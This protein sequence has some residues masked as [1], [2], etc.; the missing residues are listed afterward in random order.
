MDDEKA[1][2]TYVGN[3]EKPHEPQEN[4]QMRPIAITVDGTKLEFGL[5][6]DIE[7]TRFL[8]ACFCAIGQL[9]RVP[10]TRWIQG[11]PTPK[12]VEHLQVFGMEGILYRPMADHRD[13]GTLRPEVLDAEYEFMLVSARAI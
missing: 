11:D 7:T 3:N 13:R 1:E 9:L 2:K 4:Q 5:Q 6:L 12:V 8:E 10:K